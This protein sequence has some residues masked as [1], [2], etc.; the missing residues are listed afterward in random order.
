MSALYIKCPSQ[1]HHQKVP[2]A[3]HLSVEHQMPHS[4]Q[5]DGSTTSC[6]KAG[7]IRYT[8]TQLYHHRKTDHSLL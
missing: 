6:R 5:D 3:R 7:G 8:S 2:K 4:K 1:G